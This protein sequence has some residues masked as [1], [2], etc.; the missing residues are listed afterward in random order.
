MTRCL[1]S[2]NLLQAAILC[3][4]LFLLSC[5]NDD[6]EINAWTEK[7]VMVEE[8]KGVTTLFSQ[9]GELRAKLRAPLMLRYQSDT[10]MVE[11]PKTLHVD[12]YD[13]TRKVES[14]LDA[15]YGKYFE[16]FNKVLLRDSVR[17]VNI[18]GDTLVTPEL[19]WDQNRKLFYTDSVVRITTKDKKVRGGKGLEAGQDMSWYIIKY[20]EGTLML[21]DQILPVE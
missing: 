14:W 7:T 1:S 8:A 17:V 16:S 15:N 3:S 10:I 5:E 12:F 20:P 19:W 9:Q 13:S 6:R 4:C 21:D 11:F 18:Q 2:F